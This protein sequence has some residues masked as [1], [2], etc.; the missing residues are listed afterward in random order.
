MSH[1]VNVV[2][3]PDKL[4]ARLEFV[5]EG[6]ENGFYVV[7]LRVVLIQMREMFLKAHHPFLILSIRMSVICHKIACRILKKNTIFYISLL[8]YQLFTFF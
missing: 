6:E 2:Y 4:F 8:R 7:A 5:G 3:E 1:P